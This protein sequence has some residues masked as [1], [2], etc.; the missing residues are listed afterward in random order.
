MARSGIKEPGA[1]TAAAAERDA[2]PPWLVVRG[3]A[4][5]NL[6]EIDVA[7]PLG[8]FICVTGVSG[9]GKS[10]L[11]NEIL[12]EQLARDLNGAEATQPGR[13]RA[14]EGKEH[15]DKIIAIDQSPIGRTPR[16]NPA[17]YIKVF[18]EIRDLFAELPESKVRG[19]APGRFSF[20]VPASGEG[21]ADSKRNKRGG[22]AASGGG[23]C[24]ACEGHGA[25]RVEM[26]F[27]ADVWV[28]CPI[29]EG[30]RFSR[31]TLA[32]RFRGKSISDVLDM[33]VQEALT[34]FENI[35]HIAAA[36]RTLH[37]V[38]L[39]YLKLGQSSTT[40]SGGEAQRIKLARELVR[41]ST[42]RT[43][44]LLD[45]P[46]TGLHFE[47]VRR[48]LDVLHGFVNA[49]NTVMVIEH[50]L[51]VIKTADWV[52]DLGPEGGAAGGR[53]V[54]E[55][56]PEQ[57]AAVDASYTGQ[58]L[59][60]LL[61]IKRSG[62][63][64]IPAS[65]KTAAKKLRKPA[66][67]APPVEVI[68]VIGAREHNL[69]DVTVDV[70]RNAMT[71][72]S[73]PS[74]SGKSSFAI[75]T[76]YTEGHRRYVESLSSYARQFLGQLQ[77]PR[78]DHIYGLS[79]AIAIE[80]KSASR[81]PR[82]TVGTVTEIYDYMRVLWA[83][84]GV[85]HCPRCGTA[86]GAATR[87]EV[88]FR[89]LA[90]PEGTRVLLCAPIERS[91]GESYAEL[92]ERYRT[93]GFARVRIDGRVHPLEGKVPA[94]DRRRHAVQLVIDR[95]VV[96]AA[97]RGRLTDSIETCLAV[98]R[99]VMIA[100]V[101]EGD[102]A[103]AAE[104][105][106][107]DI[108]GGREMRLSQHLSCDTCGTAYEELT[109]NHFSFNSRLGW[110]ESC[111]GLGLQRGTRADAVAACPRRSLL[112]GALA[113]IPA[114]DKRPM[115]RPLLEALAKQIGFDPRTP[116]CDL[117]PAHQHKIL[118]GTGD[119]WISV[120]GSVGAGD[121]E[122]SKPSRQPFE[123]RVQ[124]KGFFPAINE[125]TRASWQY[126]MRLDSLVTEVPCEQCG[127]GRLRREPACVRLE[128][129]TIIEVAS[130]PLEAAARFFDGLKLDARRARIAGEVLR[131]IRARLRFL[132]DVGLGYL[133]LARA[134]PT[135]SGGESQ[136]IRLASQVG[137]GLTGVLYVLD[138]PTIGLHPR[139]NGRLIAALHR[140][141]DLGN[142]LLMVEHDREV[143]EA[144]DH[145]LDFGP[146][147][148]REGGRLVGEGAPARLRKSP[149]SLT[150]R[151]LSGREAVGVPANRRGPVAPDERITIVGARHHNL[152]GVD[153]V[154]PLGRF[155]CVTGVS[156]SG[157][158]S[159]IIDVLYPAA[160]QQLSR[161][162]EV[163]GAHEEIRG[164]NK[165]DKV[166]LVDQ[167]PIGNSPL[168]NAATYTGLFDIIREIFARLPDSKVRGYTA[169]RFSFNRPGGRCDACEGLGQVRHEM[170]FLPD[171][172][173]ECETC[174]GQRFNRETL[175]VRF[176]GRNIA[177]VLAMNAAT[178]MALFESIPRAKRI[179]QTLV[180]VGLGYLPLGQSAP[181]LSG[182]EA[183]RVKLAGELG[184]AATGRTLYVLDE[185]TTGLHVDD[186]RKLL[187]V[188]HRLVDLGNSVICIEHNL[189]VI[190]TADW[191]ID[192]GPEAGGAGGRIVAEGPPETI[193]A[194]RDSHTGRALAPV[195]KAGPRIE[196]PR[197]EPVKAE[198]ERLQR[199]S[200]TPLELWGEEAERM[201]W[202]R[203]GRRWHLEMRP[204][205]NGEPV[206]WKSDVLE[207]IVE[208]VE[209][210]GGDRFAPTDWNDR[211]CVEIRA[212][213]GAKSR[214]G[215]A[216]W[217]M[218]ALTGGQWLLDVSFRVPRGTFD[219]ADLI[220]R[221]K[222]RT[223][224]DRNDLP[225]YS[226][227]PRLYVRSVAGDME[228]VRVQ[229]HDLP[230]TDT[231]AMRRLI[232][233]AVQA[234]F[235]NVTPAAPGKG[236][237]AEPWRADGRAWHLGQKTLPPG[238]EV[239]WK[240]GT[241]IDLLGRLGRT[242]PGLSVDWGHRSRLELSLQGRMIG[243]LRTNSLHGLQ[244]ELL[245][246]PGRLATTD[247]TDAGVDGQLQ[248]GTPAG[249]DTLQMI[250][251]TGEEA[252]RPEL[253]GLVGRALEN[254]NP[255]EPKR[256][257]TDRARAGAGS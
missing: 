178:A 16:S 40:L 41:R 129:Q 153:A 135:L 27:L 106:D 59:R 97:Q 131:E 248:R 172:W 222:L 96:R 38:G 23:R 53:I 91:P 138:E 119:D 215:G 235:K 176:R 115:L 197:Y 217:F 163:L 196:R 157:K 151:Y 137:S 113:G 82:S 36:L 60:P 94:D 31:D 48:L 149:E 44:Y 211:A 29:C 152:A 249:S 168:S 242:L 58:A 144:A 24:E 155:V 184:R 32:V 200:E 102:A 204:S 208:Q 25:N 238:R 180:D 175:D 150:G 47:D 247:L 49:G 50:H 83:R 173:V 124:F 142:T 57:V 212:A 80:Q 89:I 134:A 109:P 145:V 189:E 214:T 182:G 226:G 234:Y 164:L 205:R 161:A 250:I 17:T 75:D 13:H 141:R 28:T 85:P 233:Q 77:K 33:D 220:R 4:Q 167:S 162:Q 117:A 98:G 186:L 86:V 139:D 74:G 210:L 223:L 156:G 51:D 105:D 202:E 198:R 8:R 55:G 43:L 42:G 240:P 190:K 218:H 6:K 5:N 154:I 252:R 229:L 22:A 11:V 245:T 209:K 244:L 194:S 191:V 26:D 257:G 143:I 108:R 201:P 81:S 90:L 95:A 122:G 170:H 230:E 188:L 15:L 177:D 140:L 243:W 169:N 56:T 255:S 103:R 193:A 111:E 147:A 87:D 228:N 227:E 221:L 99:G 68:R 239:Q 179:L 21:G 52:I 126:R 1:V 64:P 165:L 120:R 148:G 116:W 130:Q 9:S 54:A 63:K 73:G 171:V 192:L 187:E 7:I 92:F 133:S 254:P 121:E 246:A 71:V 181:T 100:V 236:A 118:F 231:P 219:A 67:V 159:L 93:S 224:D 66:G 132:L 62:S 207:F 18:D 2:A 216:A 128:G 45:E 70:P 101:L 69:H 127:G 146:G 158:S 213:G 10:S 110:C 65:R 14:I 203:D 237:A 107:S 251:R 256:R 136:R 12:Y 104:G 253:H 39:D 166:I 3:A 37:D 30:R 160:A 34:H 20:N 19:Y 72:C 241:L 79:P 185:P 183:Q 206:K 195:L 61:S 174:R 125:A 35:P 46:T 112:E 88:A 76:V 84:V 114:V 78:V 123:F 232:A 199:A 225:V